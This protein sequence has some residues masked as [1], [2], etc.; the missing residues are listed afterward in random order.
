MQEVQRHVA[1]Q[2]IVVVAAPPS[3]QSAP[4][5]LMTTP[6]DCSW[7]SDVEHFLPSYLSPRMELGRGSETCSTHHLD[8][9]TAGPVFLDLYLTVPG[10]SRRARLGTH[11]AL[12]TIALDPF[13]AELCVLPPTSS[14]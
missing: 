4:K 7:W 6:R 8:P 12:S 1:W 10:T 11:G 3:L 9:G 14:D 13:L 5:P 2:K